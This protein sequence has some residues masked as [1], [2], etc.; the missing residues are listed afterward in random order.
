MRSYLFFRLSAL[1]AVGP[2]AARAAEP[3]TLLPEIVAL[4]ADPL[5]RPVRVRARPALPGK[6][7]RTGEQ[8][9]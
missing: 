7:A 2:L 3:L 4:R 1:P 5:V 6:Y 8:T 9:L